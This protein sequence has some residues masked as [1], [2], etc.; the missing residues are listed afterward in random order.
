MNKKYTALLLALLVAAAEAN[1]LANAIK[2][3][4]LSN[5]KNWDG[6][7][8]HAD[9]NDYVD[10][11]IHMIVPFMREYGFDP[12]SLPDVEEGFEVRPVLITYSAWLRITNGYMTGLV[13]VERSGD[14]RVQYFA[15]MLRV[16]VQL[17]FRDL[18]FIYR[19]LVKVMRIGPTGGIIGSLN[20]FVVIFDVLIDF[21]N[22]ELHLQQFSLTDIGRLRVRF[23]GNILT[24]WLVNPVIGVFTRI[25]DTIIIRVVEINIRNGIQDALDFIN[26]NVRNI[27]QNLESQGFNY[28]INY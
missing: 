3:K 2:P 13:N 25:F 28:M 24:D 16:R 12:M 11:T 7:G 5:E 6:L 18:E 1:S 20:R 9:V 15:K 19:Y 8:L 21:N 17:Q 23:T 22:D 27:M 14:Q 4:L 10:K 26:T